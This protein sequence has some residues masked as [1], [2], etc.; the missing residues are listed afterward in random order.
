MELRVPVLGPDSLELGGGG[1]GHH[2]GQ[3]GHLAGR[4][5]RARPSRKGKVLAR[6]H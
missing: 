2:G 5:S 4:E 1:P 3:K 6:E